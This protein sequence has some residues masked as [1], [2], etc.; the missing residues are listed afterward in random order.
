MRKLLIGL[1]LAITWPVAAITN[2]VT[3]GPGG[4]S[5]S[6]KALTNHVNDT[7]AWSLGL[8]IT[9][10]VTGDTLPD[11]FCGTNH[12]CTVT[13]TAAGMYPYHCI[14]HQALGMVGSVT[15][16]DVPRPSLVNMA[17]S[18]AAFEFDL[19]TVPRLTYV[20][21]F[22]DEFLTSWAMLGQGT[23]ISNRLHFQRLFGPAPPQSFYRA[24]IK[25]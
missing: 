23:A 5:F 21:E 7:V 24:F 12:A 9:H 1:V 6:P 8:G 22:T 10:T 17:Y 20:V 3:V 25:P 18:T 19:V 15:V 14:P 11:S 2:V 13:F 16:V 4:L